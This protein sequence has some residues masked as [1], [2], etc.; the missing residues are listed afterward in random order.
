MDEEAAFLSGEETDGGDEALVGGD[1]PAVP[2]IGGTGTNAPPA[3]GINALPARWWERQA[4]APSIDYGRVNA[5]RDL[6]N[7][8]PTK[9]AN[10]AVEMATRL[11]GV[12][13]FDADVK[14]GVPTMEALRKWAPK[15]YFNHP[16]AVS[17]LVQPPFTPSMT[18]VGGHNLIQTSP[19]RF[20]FPPVP[21][22]AEE[23]GDIAL[24]PMV[25]PEGKVLGFGRQTKAGLHAKWNTPEVPD[26]KASDEIRRLTALANGY[27]KAADAAG[28]REEASKL[29]KKHLEA[30]DS[31]EQLRS[32]KIA[33]PASGELPVITTKEQYDALPH[34]ATYLNGKSNKPH[35]KP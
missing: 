28:S 2:L 1:V 30:L 5:L 21:P 22:A 4:P 7:T 18:N 17:R 8:V 32:R 24:R 33:A 16:G 26:V 25:T 14:S 31:L 10:Q 6:Y 27:Q 23:T 3:T 9:E 15:L 13:G 35:R 19:Q 34:G 12:L 20:Q 11:E 29:Q